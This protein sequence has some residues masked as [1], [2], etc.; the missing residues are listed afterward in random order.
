M[1]FKQSL[2]ASLLIG[3]G[4]ISAPLSVLANDSTEL[5]QLRALVQELDQKVRVLDRKNELA[6]EAADAKK[7]ETPI[8]KASEKGFGFQS[9]DGKFEIK[10]RGL[11]QA[12]ARYFDS[13]TNIAT[14][15]APGGSTPGYL[16]NSDAFNTWLPRRLR[17]TIEGTVFE[18][19]DFRFTPE[20]GGN[21]V[22]SDSGIV[23]AYVDARFTPELQLRVGKFKPYVGLERLQS[24]AD[25]KFVERSYVT[26]ALLP[27]RDIGASLHGNLLG[28]KLSYGLGIFNGVAD[29][30]DNT[31][32]SDINNAKDFAARLFAIPFKDSDSPLAGLG[33][34]IAATYGDVT[35]KTQDTVG[36]SVT[37]L[38][39]GYKTEGQQTFFRYNDSSVLISGPALSQSANAPGTDWLVH[40]DGKRYRI[41]PQANYYYG[42]LGVTAEYARVSQ[43]VSIGSLNS[44][45][46]TLNHEAWEIGASYLMTGEDAAFK[47]VKPKRDFDINSG[48]WGA[49][50]LVARYSEI[51]LDDK[52]FTFGTTNGV[53]AATNVAHWLYAD[54]HISSK[55]AQTWTIGAN[56]YLNPEVKFALNYVQ[57][58]FDGGGGPYVSPTSTSTYPISLKTNGSVF[59]R[60]DERALLARFQIA[61]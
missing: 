30:G 40:A 56:W 46:T 16:N 50:E 22:L 12:D 31:T 32:S 5:E 60:P 9:G 24:A 27:N 28:G 38:T 15:A 57:T 18:K 42:P 20:F 19:Y 7:K 34:G 51:N 53:N 8:L 11:I 21:S 39:S 29:G 43:G 23:D 61:L 14:Q 33:F 52:T 13:G 36:A 37:E 59:D 4:I 35:G 44:N 49:W 6:A 26:N 2:L 58:T 47:G 10:L 41:A 48:G 54:P 55:S 1:Q 3:S 17:P 45:Q 25:I